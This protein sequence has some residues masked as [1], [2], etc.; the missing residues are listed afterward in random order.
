LK[1]PAITVV[2]VSSLQEIAKKKCAWKT[3]IREPKLWI[4]SCVRNF[5]GKDILLSTIRAAISD[6]EGAISLP[7]VS[8]TFV[9]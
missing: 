5:F 7:S 8:T 3:S 6:G 4:Y 1:T 2:A 9:G